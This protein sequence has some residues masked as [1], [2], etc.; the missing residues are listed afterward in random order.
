MRGRGIVEVLQTV[1]ENLPELPDVNF[2]GHEFN[3][4]NF[5]KRDADEEDGLHRGGGGD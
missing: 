1:A 4:V 3:F 2:G 5:N